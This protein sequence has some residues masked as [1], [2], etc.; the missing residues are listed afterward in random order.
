MLLKFLPQE[1]QRQGGAVDGGGELLEKEGHRADMVFVGV[2]Q[3]QGHELVPA[4]PQISKIGNNDVDPQHGIFGKHEAR[5]HHHQVV[6]GLQGHHVE[7]DLPHASQKGEIHP[8]I[9]GSLS[10]P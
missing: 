7:A 10:G 1:G 4:L 9:V 5:I 6:G 8:V 2:G 3:D